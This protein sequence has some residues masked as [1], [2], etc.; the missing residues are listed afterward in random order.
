MS[1]MYEYF[2]R[3]ANGTPEER[4]EA[5]SMLTDAHEIAQDWCED[6]ESGQAEAFAERVYSTIDAIPRGTQ[7][8]E[9]ELKRRHE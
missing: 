9:A 2:V 8:F 3:K 5:I 1:E 6:D 4:E 7:A